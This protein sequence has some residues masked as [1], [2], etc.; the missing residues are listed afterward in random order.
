MAKMASVAAEAVE[1]PVE[2]APE[3]TITVEYTPTSREALVL[4]GETFE[5]APFPTP[6]LETSPLEGVAIELAPMEAGAPALERKPCPGSCPV[7][8]CQNCGQS[9]AD[10]AS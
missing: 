9:I 2:D 4:P 1:A 3:A 8:Y 10:L 6:V 5:M 7:G